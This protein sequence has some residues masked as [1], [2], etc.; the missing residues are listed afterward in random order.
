MKLQ[1]RFK[2]EK[3][4]VFTEEVTK[5]ALT[6]NDDKKIQSIY[7]IETDAYRTKKDLIGTKEEIK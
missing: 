2:R 5:I 4:N 6:L 1:Q 3:H 7:S